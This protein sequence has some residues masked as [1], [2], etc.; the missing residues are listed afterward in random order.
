M[1]IKRL[2]IRHRF[3]I[4]FDTSSFDNIITKWKLYY[5]LTFLIMPYGIIKVLFLHAFSSILYGYIFKTS[6]ICKNFDG[7][8]SNPTSSFF[9]HTCK[10]KL[11]DVGISLRIISG[12]G[13]ERIQQNWVS[14]NNTGL[15]GYYFDFPSF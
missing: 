3:T 15:P 9:T 7:K 14:C 1:C 12:I 6:S 10:L 5:E 4:S 13:P 2:S 11:L 8:F